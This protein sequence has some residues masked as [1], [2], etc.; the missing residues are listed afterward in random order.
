MATRTR[1]G[2][3]MKGRPAGISDANRQSTQ[4]QSMGGRE[5]GQI[6]EPMQAQMASGNCGLAEDSGEA[7]EEPKQEAA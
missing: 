5:F 7:P 6:I 3:S 1:S 2:K 4:S